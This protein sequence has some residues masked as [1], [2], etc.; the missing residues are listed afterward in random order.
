[1]ASKL[2][3][4]LALA[5]QGFKVF[6]ITPG[7]KA[8]P[9]ITDWPRN[10][11]SDP[12]VI[13][14]MWS[15]EPGQN[16]IGIH[17]E[18]LLVV[19][20]DI[21]KGGLESFKKLDD[22]LGFPN[23]RTHGT[24]TGGLHAIYRL[25]EGHPGVPNSVGTATSGLAQG[26]D[27]RSTGGYIVAPGSQIGD[28]ILNP[29]HVA[30]DLPIAPAPDWLVQKLGTFVRRERAEESSVPD[31]SPDVVERAQAWLQTAER[32][33]KGAGGDQTAYRVA[34][35]LR[36][37][38]LSYLQACE[39]MRS[40][41]WDW[42]CG[43]REGRLEEK[44][45]RSAYKYAQNDPGVKVVTASMFT[46]LPA[47]PKVVRRARSLKEIAQTKGRH[48]YLVKGYLRKGTYAQIFG[49]PGE[50][51]TFVAL[52]IA[53]CVAAGL[54]WM[55]C[56]VKAGPVLYVA[57]EGS[58]ENRAKALLQKHGDADVP[59]HVIDAAMNLRTA[60]GLE[61]LNAVIADL[62]AKPVLI[63]IDTFARAMMGGDENSAQD[64]GDFNSAV[65]ALIESTGACVLIIHH[66]GK[67]K[68]AGARG[69]SA[70]NGALDTSLEI[71]A[72]QII[73]EKQREGEA[74]PVIGFTLTKLDVGKDEDGDVETSCVVEPSTI[75][76]GGKPL[77]PKLE[78]AFA[79]LSKLTGPE[80]KPVT[81]NAWA[82]AL[83]DEGFGKD[84]AYSC[85][86]KLEKA[87][88]VTIVDKMVNRR[89]V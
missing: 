42:G 88:R 5:A 53:Y 85:H 63:V 3:H 36:D 51:K 22:M 9:L 6:P 67:N 69:S 25:P 70:L 45:I 38:G 14:R 20:V 74:R 15:N 68:A 39:A 40:E 31:A 83:R 43:W 8:P 37:Q 47:A 58:L 55:K 33:V 54:E 4:A 19:D 35:A 46:A 23:T 62:P 12:V 13:N 52:D 61:E 77:T 10:A 76:P 81:R 65:A 78:H 28:A 87:L 64:V 49:A 75:A 84:A 89:M 41:A 18:G 34:C 24:P 17:C 86:F 56:K 32:S 21:H 44:P 73:S 59:L 66:S 60:A 50:G 11:T 26:L 72:K 57:Y 79:V 82:T 27:I 2:E 48:P 71:D 29:Y 7:A 30:V 80:N 1:M 16:N